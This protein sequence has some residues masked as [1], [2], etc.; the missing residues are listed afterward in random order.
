MGWYVLHIKEGWRLLDHF[1]ASSVDVGGHWGGVLYRH[2]G[3]E[4]RSRGEDEKES[5]GEGRGEERIGEKGAE[6]GGRERGQEGR[7]R[8]RTGE[9]RK[10]K[11]RREVERIHEE[12]RG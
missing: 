6:G 12:G 3:L 7:R 4:L 1:S 8:W 2:K 11:E 10:G 5:G 9:G